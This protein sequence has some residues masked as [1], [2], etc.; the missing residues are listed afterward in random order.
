MTVLIF[1]MIIFILISIVFV[2]NKKIKH[3]IQNFIYV[4]VY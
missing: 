2:D 3:V 4:F 1:K